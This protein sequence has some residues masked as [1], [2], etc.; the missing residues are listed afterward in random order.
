MAEVNDA[1]S[2]ELAMM[3]ALL[4]ADYRLK[5]A[6]AKSSTPRGELAAR[7]AALRAEYLAAVK[8]IF[9][10]SGRVAARKLLILLV[11]GTDFSKV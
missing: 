5:V 8:L 1:A 10:S 11:W 3:H 6:D 9:D 4:I 2:S 7:L